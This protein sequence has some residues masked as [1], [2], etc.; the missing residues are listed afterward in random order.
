MVVKEI[1]L[2]IFPPSYT[3]DFKIKF[4][5]N[6]NENPN[7]T[8]WIIE[9]SQWEPFQETH[10]PQDQILHIKPTKLTKTQNP[11]TEKLESSPCSCRSSWP[12][13]DLRSP[14]PWQR[15]CTQTAHAPTISQSSTCTG[16]PYHTQN[17][18]S[19]H[20]AQPQRTFFF[21]GAAA[22]CSVVVNSHESL[23][24]FVVAAGLVVVV[25]AAV[26]IVGGCCFCCWCYWIRWPCWRLRSRHPCSSLCGWLDGE[27]FCEIT[28]NL[29]GFF[30]R[31]R[32]IQR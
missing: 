25:A 29:M 6:A 5:Y 30:L 9:S 17:R 13:R 31:E 3:Y 18:S 32:G 20:K 12:P 14:C 19:C 28:I 21:G 8:A 22:A 7:P 4:H 23:S 1:M 15:T 24:A 26:E 2:P 10:I 27:G 11:N 16:N